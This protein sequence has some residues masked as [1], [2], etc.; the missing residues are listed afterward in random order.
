MR[1]LARRAAAALAAHSAAPPSPPPCRYSVFTVMSVHVPPRPTDADPI[2][3]HIMA[4]IDNRRAPA[5]AAQALVMMR[6]TPMLQARGGG[7]AVGA[8]GVNAQAGVKRGKGF[9]S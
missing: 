2:V 1:A 5:C 8:V 3:I 7:L 4:A 6:L 9:C